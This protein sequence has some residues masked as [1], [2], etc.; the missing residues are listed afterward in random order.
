MFWRFLKFSIISVL[1]LLFISSLALWAFLTVWVPTDGKAL[2]IEQVEARWPI[3]LKIGSMGYSPLKGLTLDHV[4]VGPSDTDEVWLQCSQATARVHWWSLPMQ[5]VDF[6]IKSSL[7]KPAQANL[8]ADGHYGWETGT[9]GLRLRIEE[10]ALQTLSPLL[11][12]KIPGTVREGSLRADLFLKGAAA[13][14]IELS[15]SATTSELSWE[16]ETYKGTGDLAIEGSITAPSIADHFWKTE[17]VLTLRNGSL[18]TRSP[19]GIITEIEG[20]SRLSAQGMIIDALR[21]NVFGAAWE[22]TG[23]LD[24]WRLPRYEVLATSALSLGDL[25]AFFDSDSWKLD[26][27]ADLTAV[28]RGTLGIQPDC[29]IRAALNA[30]SL[31]YEDS[32]FGLTSIHGPITY[33]VLADSAR[34]D[35]LQAIADD[36]PVEL[37]AV[38]ERIRGEPEFSLLARFPEGALKLSG[39]HTPSGISIKASSLTF[40]DSKVELTGELALDPAKASRLTLRGILEPASILLLPFA[41]KLI[42]AFPPVDGAIGIGLRYNGMLTDWKSA[43]FEGQLG[44]DQL[45]L[46]GTPF[47]NV[48]IEFQQSQGKLQVSTQQ[49]Q[50]AQGLIWSGLILT[51]IQDTSDFQW[52]LD[53]TNL[54]LDLLAQAVPQLNDREIQG[55]VSAH[56]IIQGRLDQRDSWSGEGWLNAQGD[57][58]GDLPLF[59]TLIQKLFG[60]LGGRLKLDSL[61]KAK[62]QE[63]SLRWR[64]ADARIATDDLRLGAMAG[65]DPVAVYAKGSLGLDHT[66]D[67]VIE[68][69]FSNQTVT[70]A[71]KS[72]SLAQVILQAAGRFEQLRQLIGQHRLTGTIEEPIYRFELGAGENL[73]RVTPG[74]ANLLQGI[75]RSLQ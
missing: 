38:I 44:A 43:E 3:S 53:A 54:Q 22:L 1:T 75:I 30:A 15:G 67:F 21:G 73:K 60:T 8:M 66:L 25:S 32:A 68:P 55:T 16:N 34:T 4:T 6:R 59:D 58:L 29:L 31:W 74:P 26:G 36:Q 37:D 17:A 33:D 18:E 39:K 23:T 62:L 11:A 27:A 72:S 51:H 63:V 2:L 57:R 12:G 69:E 20:S 71:P 49:A 61:R 42:Q 35:Q 14:S 24:S 28:C 19:V 56:A 9:W 10:A 40:A 48:R 45:H 50:I 46:A 47:E 5:R 70:E 41:G 13:A 65:Q 64:L 7:T 52:Q